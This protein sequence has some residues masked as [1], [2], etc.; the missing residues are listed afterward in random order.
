MGYLQA[1]EMAR[2]ANLDIALFWHLTSNHYPPL[3]KSLIK[4]C[5]EAIR[6][7]LA[8]EWDKEIDLPEG[9]ALGSVTTVP[10]RRI[11]EACHLEAFIDTYS[12]KDDDD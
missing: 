7:A 4:P 1:S 2:Y 9:I 10:T 8:E 6:N 5:K 12:G 11:V 3:P